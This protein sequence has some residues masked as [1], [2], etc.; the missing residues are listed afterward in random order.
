MVAPG[1]V[2]SVQEVDLGLNGGA[3]VLAFRVL[4][5]EDVVVH[6]YLLEIACAEAVESSFSCCG[7]NVERVMIEVFVAAVCGESQRGEETESESRKFHD[8]M[9]DCRKRV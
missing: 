9:N 8:V 5:Y 6:V 7:G 2:V 3:P 1:L 4:R